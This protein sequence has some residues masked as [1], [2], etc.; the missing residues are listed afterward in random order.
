M[1]YMLD[2]NTVSDLL[3]GNETVT[4]HLR[5]HQ[6]ADIVL[7]AVTEG[8]LRYGLANNPEASRLIE[9]VNQ[10]LKTLQ[11]LPWDSKAAAA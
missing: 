5:R 9:A 7:S 4:G 1:K 6:P 3:K 8:E 2:T 10:V 11:V